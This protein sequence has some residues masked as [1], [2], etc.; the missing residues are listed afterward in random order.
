MAKVRPGSDS[1]NPIALA[2]RVIALAQ[3]A[4]EK[5]ND[6]ATDAKAR[7][8]IV[9]RLNRAAVALTPRRPKWSWSATQHAVF[10]V[11]ELMSEEMGSGRDEP[12]IDSTVNHIANVM[13]DMFAPRELRGRR[14]ERD[15]VAACLRAPKGRGRPPAGSVSAGEARLMLLK[16]LGVTNATTPGA[17]SKTVERTRARRR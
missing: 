16:Q 12:V 6:R 5:L 9:A 2:A 14:P 3:K 10:Y 17:V 13:N 11:L 1:S 7:A 4:A 8:E 15:L